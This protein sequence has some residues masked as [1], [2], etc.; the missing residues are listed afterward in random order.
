[1]KVSQPYMTNPTH[2]TPGQLIQEL[3]DQRG[4]TK[5]VLAIVLEINETALNK[6]I[7][8]GRALD[9]QL[10]LALQEVFD[11]P[12]ERFLELQKTYDLAQALIVTSPDPGLKNRA[13]LFGDLPV[14]EMIKRGWIA[15]D[16][17]RNVPQVQAELMRFFGADSPDQIEV[18]PH[19]AKKTLVS[20]TAVTPAQLAWLYR[21]REIAD[22]L[23]VARYSPEA[24]QQAIER[25]RILRSSPEE[26]RKVPRIL[27]DAGIRYVVVEALPGSKIDGVCFWL[28][29]S[30]PVIGMSL[31][32]DRIDNF[33][34]VL[35]HELE[36]V[37]R[38]DGRTLMMLDTDLEGELAGVGDHIPAVERAANV[39]AANFCVPD[40]EMIQFVNRKAPFFHEKDI[41]GFARTIKVH[42]GLVAGQLQHRINR[43]DR[44]RQHLVK[45][46]AFVLPSAPKDGWGDVY[47]VG[48]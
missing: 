31:R 47:P 6:I 13:L 41:I 5:R 16:D 33:W 4:W 22:E 42:P 28:D 46:R 27:Q 15:A 1:M 26:A 37:L 34:F 12:A 39:E 20:T 30:S 14:T 21:V 11:V 36:H 35:R 32:F 9:A 3:L 7:N 48:I 43:Y 17:I 2:R 40:S 24:V 38:L 45:I 25:L 10:A 8:G 19:A 23:L 18:L 44:F 29:D